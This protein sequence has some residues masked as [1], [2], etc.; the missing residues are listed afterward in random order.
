MRALQ[1]S[2]HESHELSC[3]LQSSS[4][5][6]ERHL[7]LQSLG[8][9]LRTSAALSNNNAEGKTPCAA[10]ILRHWQPIEAALLGQISKKSSR[11]RW[12]LHQHFKHWTQ[13]ASM[14]RTGQISTQIPAQSNKLMKVRSIRIKNVPSNLNFISTQ[15][16]HTLFLTCLV[17]SMQVWTGFFFLSYFIKRVNFHTKS[18]KQAP[19][20]QKLS[21]HCKPQSRYSA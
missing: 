20:L 6:T 5:P 18:C 16:L 7:Q 9:E 3:A 13:Q 19:I 21:Y 2:S 17:S 12:E 8:D 15:V 10:E 4:H 14:K 11:H 1:F